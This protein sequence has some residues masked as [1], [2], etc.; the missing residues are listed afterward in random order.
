MSR[1][2]TYQN[3]TG[4]DGEPVSVPVVPPDATLEE[5]EEIVSAE[6][7]AIMTDEQQAAFDKHVSEGVTRD[8]RAR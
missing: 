3:R 6:G 4:P 1:P 5:I 8:G 2:L 7:A